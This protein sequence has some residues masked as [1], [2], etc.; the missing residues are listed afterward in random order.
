MQ[1]QSFI[2]RQTNTVIFIISIIILAT[3]S[4][5][6]KPLN[7]S[8]Y[9][10]LVNGKVVTIE[11]I[12]IN[13]ACCP[14]NSLQRA[15]AKFDEYVLGEVRLIDK[16]RIILEL[17]T[18]NAISREQFDKIISDSNIGQSIINMIIVP[19]HEFFHSRG[20]YS[21][22]KNGENAEICNIISINAKT[23][24]KTSA[25]VPFISREELWRIVI[26]HELC[27][28]LNVP[29]RNSHIKEGKHCSNADCILYPKIDCLSALTAIFNFGAPDGLCKKCQTEILQAH[30]QT[31]GN[32]YDNSQSF[33]RFGR[34]IEL[35][36]GNIEAVAA[37]AF[38]ELVYKNNE[39][40]IE[41]FD[42]LIAEKPKYK[43]PGVNNGTSAFALRAVCYANL[44][45]YDKAVSDCQKA[46]EIMPDDLTVLKTYSRMLGTAK[47]DDLRNG[48]LAVK[49]AQKACEL[50]KWNNPESLDILACAYAE[51]GDFENAIKY[52][53]QAIEL[54][55]KFNEEYSKH[56][57]LFNKQLPYRQ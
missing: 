34:L 9:E 25:K 41:Y 15:V 37:A 21:W 35:N 10:P 57:E 48:S 36:P 44:K 52:E 4:I 51:K 16:G 2:F 12:C 55:A 27:H 32:F 24:D 19:E 11:V 13:D 28:S 5:V 46:I 47:Q 7:E 26:L 39:K 29:A 33:N 56:S 17:G 20:F 30:K 1:K 14:D 18:D 43:Y 49:L 6:A 45:K 54:S 23:C 31:D 40:A 53:Q 42:I 38:Y 22:A 50:E 8:V 3:C